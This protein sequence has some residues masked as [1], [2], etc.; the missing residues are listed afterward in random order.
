MYIGNYF[1]DYQGQLSVINDATIVNAN[2]TAKGNLLINHH[3]KYFLDDYKNG[4]LSHRGFGF[5]G[6]F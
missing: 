5:G 4:G 2:Q 1:L 3:G 6:V